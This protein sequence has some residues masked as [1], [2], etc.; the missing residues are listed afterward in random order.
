MLLRYKYTQGWL[1]LSKLRED[2][3][4]LQEFSMPQ[5]EFA[6][7]HSRYRGG[8]R[9]YATMREGETLIALS[10]HLRQS[11]REQAF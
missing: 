5:L 4:R 10:D 7:R 9:F 6:A 8:F 2:H 11:R 3:D 1:V